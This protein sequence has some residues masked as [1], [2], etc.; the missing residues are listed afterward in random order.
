MIMAEH[1]K[2]LCNKCGSHEFVYDSYWKEYS[3]KN[4]GWIAEGDGK[5]SAAEK[6]GRENIGKDPSMAKKPSKVSGRKKLKINYRLVIEILVI[7]TIV[8]LLFPRTRDELHWRWASVS[9]EANSYTAYLKSWPEGR[10]AKEAKSLYD[11]RSWSD[12]LAADRIPAL[13]FY[14]NAHPKGKHVAEARNKVEVLTWRQATSDNTIKS[15]QTYIGTHPKGKHVAKARNKV[16][17]LTWRQA[18]SGNTIKSYQTYIKTHPEGKH[19]AEARGKIEELTWRQAISD[20]TIKSYQTYI[21]AYPNGRFIAD[22]KSRQIALRADN[23]PFLEARNQGSKQALKRFFV[24]F[25]GH[26]R[27]ADARA[28]LRD[29]QGPDIVD[30]LQ[31]KKIEVEIQGSGIKS[32]RVK[33]RRLVPHSVTVLIPVGTFFVSRK[34][35]SQNMV[36][37]A[38][39][40]K[41]IS[42]DDWVWL[43]PSA[44]CANRSRDIPVSSD[45]FTVQRSPNQVELE[46]LMHILDMAGVNNAVRQ[47]AVWIV[48]DNADYSDLGILVSRSTLQVFGGTRQIKEYESAKAMKICEEAGIDVTRKAIWRNRKRI[49]EGLKDDELRRWLMERGTTLNS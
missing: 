18:I 48:T 30:L 21:G 17:V 10:H 35:S 44:A 23:A 39:S 4:C 14:I 36:T 45:S 43:N 46:R 41:T 28:A 42:D 5:I 29:L 3:C 33:V 31:E 1:Q 26:K 16:E 32:V 24:E 15:Y 37:T 27:E 19:V 22:A 6:I 7:G 34:A 38:E 20:N 11:D 9:D 8:L 40:K 25:P 47:A 12:A 49:L 13:R 2:P